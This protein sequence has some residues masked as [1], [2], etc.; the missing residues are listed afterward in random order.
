MGSP[1]LT[2]PNLWGQG[3][4]GKL[5][6][7]G[8]RKLNM[9]SRHVILVAYTVHNQPTLMVLESLGGHQWRHAWEIL[10]ATTVSMVDGCGLLC[11]ALYFR[12]RCIDNNHN[13]SPT[14]SLTSS[15]QLSW[16]WHTPCCRLCHWMKSCPNEHDD[17]FNSPSQTQPMRTLYCLS[18]FPHGQP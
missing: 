18:I 5:Q 13:L 17:M 10:Y 3:F 11:L 4:V 1:H 9:G 2:S 12:I 8:A 16:I 6:V 15:N 7:E 14:S